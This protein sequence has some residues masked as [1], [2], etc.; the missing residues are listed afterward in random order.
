MRGRSREAGRARETA[1]AGTR[2]SS[3]IGV[4]IPALL[5]SFPGRFDVI[6]S[7]AKNLP[8]LPP[9]RPSPQGTPARSRS[10]AK[11]KGS[12]WQAWGPGRRRPPPAQQ[13]RRQDAREAD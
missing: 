7:E 13:Q 10:G 1:P 6:L 5:A 3:A 9:D 4:I 11:P 2:E 8:P 12:G